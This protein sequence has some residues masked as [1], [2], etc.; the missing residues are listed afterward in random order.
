M[1]FKRKKGRK[2]KGKK[3]QPSESFKDRMKRLKK[4][5]ASHSQ[6]VSTKQQ[7]VSSPGQKQETASAPV[8]PSFQP[9]TAA[10]SPSLSSTL[11][12]PQVPLSSAAEDDGDEIIMLDDDGDA[13]IMLNDDGEE[14]PY[15]PQKD[16]L[17]FSQPSEEIPLPRTEVPESPFSQL[18]ET[19]SPEVSVSGEAY[20][21]SPGVAQAGD[22][23]A[24]DEL[25]LAEILQDAAADTAELS[26][27]DSSDESPSTPEPVKESASWH[28]RPALKKPTA[29]KWGGKDST[30][31]LLPKRPGEQGYALDDELTQ[32]DFKDITNVQR[33]LRLNEEEFDLVEKKFPDKVEIE[34]YLEESERWWQEW[35][36]SI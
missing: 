7:A 10:L 25:D 2:G 9:S 23:E 24:E 21:E 14:T 13:I 32:M 3:N 34:A 17:P 19:V 36:D 27:S 22:D 26:W 30:T 31:T 15:R 33:R 28:S 20:S 35:K 16:V 8:T 29:R 1:T 6:T 18:P 12:S 5:E 11:P 4:L